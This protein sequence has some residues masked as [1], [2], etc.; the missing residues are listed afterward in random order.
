[1]LLEEILDEER[2]R[3]RF[4]AGSANGLPTEADVLSSKN[5]HAE[6]YC[7]RRDSS[8]RDALVLES[9]SP[10]PQFLTDTSRS[11]VGCYAVPSAEDLLTM[12]SDVLFDVNRR[13]AWQAS[14]R[15]K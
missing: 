1:M 10:Q 2:S 5:V 13:I 12:P 14:L 6:R 4:P 3:A 15:M 7:A 8:R 9:N 11:A